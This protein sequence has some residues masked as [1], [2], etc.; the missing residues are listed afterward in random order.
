MRWFRRL[1]CRLF[2]HKWI[3][4]PSEWQC[5]RCKVLGAK[6][7]WHYQCRT[8]LITIDGEFRY[9]FPVTGRVKR[10]VLRRLK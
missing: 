10:K 5:S 8:K 6:L 2:K 9:G 7:P 1:L 3:E 4:Y